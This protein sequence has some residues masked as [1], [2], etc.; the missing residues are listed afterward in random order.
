MLEQ[1]T[2]MTSDDQATVNMGTFREHCYRIK[3]EL[4]QRDEEW[5]TMRECLTSK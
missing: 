1:K 2:S 5:M 3:S 4:V